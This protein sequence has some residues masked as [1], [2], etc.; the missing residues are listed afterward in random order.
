MCNHSQSIFWYIDGHPSRSCLCSFH[1]GILF[2]QEHYI[3]E[4]LDC[5]TI[6]T[7]I[8]YDGPVNSALTV[9][10]SPFGFKNH[11]PS[12]KTGIYYILSP[13]SL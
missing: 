3:I 7:V 1:V 12:I 6:L 10:L 2:R 9:F 4:C 8:W 5:N 11:P 13:I